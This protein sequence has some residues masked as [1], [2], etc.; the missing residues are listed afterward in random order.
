MVAWKPGSFTGETR[1]S[2]LAGVLLS[3]VRHV[4]SRRVSPHAHEA[5]YFSLLLEGAYSEGASDFSVRYEPY[6]LVYHDALTEHWDAIEECGC[7]MFFVELLAPWA[8]TVAA[9]SK[10]AHLFELDGSAPVW[11]IMRLY[12]EFLAGDA[13][14]PLTAESLVF[15]LCDYLAHSPLSLTREPSWIGRTEAL[16][17]ADLS[18]RV[19]VRT[20][21]AEVGVDPSH[22]C[23]SFRRFRRRTIGDYVMGLRTQFVCRALVETSDP[24]MGIAERAGF[25]DQSHM[26][27]LFKRY[28][29]A[30]PA[31][32]R[33]QMR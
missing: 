14:S 23:K 13:A 4:R 29:G 27:R 19:D 32:Y 15:E 20:L 12:R 2:Q 11:L 24:L 16:V 6:T 33:R 7:R 25:A 5:P 3:E 30:S 21:A 10:R 1:S 26:T 28:T 18:A 8:D 17:R 22:L 9:L 31:A